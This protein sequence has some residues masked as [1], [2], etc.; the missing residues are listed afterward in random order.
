MHQRPS[1][2]GFASGV[3]IIRGVPGAG[4][5]YVDVDEL[6]LES[7]IRE[8]R[9]HLLAPSDRSPCS[10][11]RPM[12]RRAARSPCATARRLGRQA[13]QPGHFP[14]SEAAAAPFD[15]PHAWTSPPCRSSP[16]ARRRRAAPRPG[17]RRRVHRAQSTPL[18]PTPRAGVPD[19]TGS[20]S[21]TAVSD[22]IRPKVVLTWTAATFP[23]RFNVL[24]NNRVRHVVCA[25]PPGHSAP[26]GVLPASPT[27]DSSL[28]SS[29]LE[30]STRPKQQ[31]RR[32]SGHQRQSRPVSRTPSRFQDP[33]CHTPLCI[34]GTYS[35]PG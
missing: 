18:P 13:A 34:V 12:H 3:G 14:H 7:A 22:A 27:A 30:I 4:L 1:G 15:R 10:A 2:L 8:T 25:V 29:S 9:H 23:D 20:T 26:T 35:R 19:A 6:R 11:A 28:D 24:R 31:T 5:P 16:A 32:C 17:P 33:M 21:L